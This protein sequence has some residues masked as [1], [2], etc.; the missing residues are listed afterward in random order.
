M[1]FWFF[2]PD[3]FGE[4]K[5]EVKA[6]DEQISKMIEKGMEAFQIDVINEVRT[7]KIK[8]TFWNRRKLKKLKIDFKE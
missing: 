7:I 6:N 8:N 4:K 5:L 2:V 3:P 1:L